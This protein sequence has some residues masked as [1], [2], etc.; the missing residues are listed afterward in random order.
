MNEKDYKIMWEW[1]GLPATIISTGLCILSILK[2][3]F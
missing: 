1:Y 2:T 3:L